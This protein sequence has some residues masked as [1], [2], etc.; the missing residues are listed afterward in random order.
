MDYFVPEDQEEDD[1][2]VH[3]ITR[4]QIAGPI[5]TEDDVPFVQKEIRNVIK[6]I[7]PRKHQELTD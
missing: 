6:N 5:D 4:T 1:K 3:K 2:T 7:T